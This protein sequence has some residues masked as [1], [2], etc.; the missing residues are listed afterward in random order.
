MI[1][2][3]GVLRYAS[4]FRHKRIARLI[5]QK[6]VIV[7]HIDDERVQIIIIY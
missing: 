7:F 2:V 5:A 6:T 3:D 4:L 1:D